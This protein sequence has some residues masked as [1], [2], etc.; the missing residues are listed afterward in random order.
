MRSFPSAIAVLAQIVLAALVRPD[1]AVSSRASGLV[2]VLSPA[3]ARFSRPA[4][5]QAARI[6]FIAA[7]GGSFAA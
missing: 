5:A 4:K 1:A 6:A 7:G 2:F 3:R